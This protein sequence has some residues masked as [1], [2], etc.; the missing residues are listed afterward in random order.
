[1]K[2]IERDYPAT[3]ERFTTLGPLMENWAM[4]AKV[5]AGTRNMRLTSL[6]S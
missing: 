5:L 1:M 2:V 6:K 4:A 3:Y